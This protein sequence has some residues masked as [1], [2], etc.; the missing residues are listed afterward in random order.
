MADDFTLVQEPRYT[1]D[2]RR[3][4]GAVKRVIVDGVPTCWRTMDYFHGNGNVKVI[5]LVQPSEDWRQAH[6]FHLVISDEIRKRWVMQPK[7]RWIVAMS[8]AAAKSWAEKH[9][10]K[11]ADR[12]S[13]LAK[14]TLGACMNRISRKTTT[15]TGVTRRAAA[16]AERWAVV[17]DKDTDDAYVLDV[18]DNLDYATA[19]LKGPDV[20]NTALKKAANKVASIINKLHTKEGFE[21]IDIPFPEVKQKRRQRRRAS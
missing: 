12:Q 4:D 9:F 18:Q 6:M 15:T 8:L 5:Q 20:I 11:I 16:T 2:Y 3:V 14:A 1:F 21:P 13:G 10:A 19:A 17:R 7:E